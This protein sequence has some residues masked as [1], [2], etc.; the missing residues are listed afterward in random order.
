MSWRVPFNWQ[1]ITLD[2]VRDC[3]VAKN[4]PLELSERQL[5][6]ISEI[7]RQMI[8]QYLIKFRQNKTKTAEALGISRQTL[9]R[10]LKEY[11]L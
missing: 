1:E 6:D 4:D 2:L 10:R 8:K 7:E 5:T 3:F 9:Y 11:N